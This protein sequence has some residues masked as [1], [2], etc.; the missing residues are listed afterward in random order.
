MSH[1][2]VDPYSG[3]SKSMRH[4]HQRRHK[5][6]LKRMYNY[7][8]D[9]W[10]PWPV[11]Y[12]DY[13]W[14]NISYQAYPSENAHLKRNWR[15]RRSKYLKTMAHRKAR[16]YKNNVYNDTYHKQFDFWWELD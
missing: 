16:R 2:Y 11:I 14:D 3:K 4:Y 7:G 15:G 8:A 13:E 1:Q 9:R 12:S 10:Y 5:A 6:K